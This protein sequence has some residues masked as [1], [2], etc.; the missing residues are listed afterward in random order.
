MRNSRPS[1]MRLLSCVAAAAIAA[2][3]GVQVHAQGSTP[4]TSPTTPAEMQ[5]GV[6]GVDVDLGT[7]GRPGTNGVPGID[8]DLSSRRPGNTDG[9][10]GVDM[11]SQR[12]GDT[13]GVAAVDGDTRTAGAGG[14]RTTGMRKPIQDRN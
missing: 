9:G 2:G 4:G 13:T 3:A 14:A 8:V 6:P 10:P 5:R 1:S 11:R 12:A 7:S